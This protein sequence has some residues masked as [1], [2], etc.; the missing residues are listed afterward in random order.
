MSLTF[1]LFMLFIC[2]CMYFS[3]N[4]LEFISMRFLF[5][6]NKDMFGSLLVFDYLSSFTILVSLWCYH[7]FLIKLLH[8]SLWVYDLYCPLS[9]HKKML[10]WFMGLLM[11]S[12]LVYSYISLCMREFLLFPPVRSISYDFLIKVGCPFVIWSEIWFNYNAGWRDWLKHFENRSSL[13][14]LG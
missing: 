12:Y 2:Y 10:I 7:S 13:S 14:F 1:C 8:P 5:F 9:C 11:R 6:D 4:N 3:W